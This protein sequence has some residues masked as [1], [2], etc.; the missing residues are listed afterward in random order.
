[1]FPCVIENTLYLK[2]IT[3][4]NI[5]LVKQIKM[6][7]FSQNK[8][9]HI[10]SLFSFTPILLRVRTHFDVFSLDVATDSHSL[11]LHTLQK[12]LHSLQRTLHPDAL[13]G[14][15]QEEIT[16]CEALSSEVN[17]AYKILKDDYSRYRYIAYCLALL[18]KGVIINNNNS[19]KEHEILQHFDKN[20]QVIVENDDIKLGEQVDVNFLDQMLELHEELEDVHTNNNTLDLERKKEMLEIVDQIAEE[21]KRTCVELLRSDLGKQFWANQI[22]EFQDTST[23]KQQQ[24]QFNNE[25]ENVAE[26]ARRKYLQAVL[27]WT[28]ARNLQI[29]IRDL[30]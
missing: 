13:V 18:R 17:Q 9:L 19:S 20:N 25:N 28:Y 14:K 11:D 16:R 4:T 22:K 3:K 24:P 21:S 8:Y 30:E 15:S 2:S 10:S 23:L 26:L 12:K 5:L 6:F 7:R 29:K 27:K 1:V